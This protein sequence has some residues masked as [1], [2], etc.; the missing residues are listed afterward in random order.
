M[1]QYG[2]CDVGMSVT[3]SY[4]VYILSVK[5]T[6]S[7][8]KLLKSF[9]LK[10]YSV[11]KHLKKIIIDDTKKFAIIEKFVF[12]HIFFLFICRKFENAD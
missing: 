6:Q 9:L 3:I 7:I 2:W 10:L 11:Y 8:L 4:C 1:S 12:F 5:Q